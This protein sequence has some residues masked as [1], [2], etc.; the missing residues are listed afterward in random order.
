M[1]V[2]GF[3]EKFDWQRAGAGAEA[4]ALLE[5]EKRDQSEG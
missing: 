4:E 3:R 2:T 1:P 5:G